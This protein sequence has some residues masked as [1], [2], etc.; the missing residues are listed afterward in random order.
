[1]ILYYMYTPWI[2]SLG[3]MPLHAMDH[4]KK[5]LENSLHNDGCVL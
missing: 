3:I 4:T 2:Y 1:M 5:I